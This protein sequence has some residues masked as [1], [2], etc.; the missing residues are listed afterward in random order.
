MALPNDVLIHILEYLRGDCTYRKRCLHTT[1]KRRTCKNR[2]MLYSVL[3]YKHE[4]IF[5]KE[6]N[7]LEA[8]IQLNR[9]MI[10]G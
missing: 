4:K 8:L 3:C 2:P 5:Q 1:K 6:M 7:P 10:P 9:F